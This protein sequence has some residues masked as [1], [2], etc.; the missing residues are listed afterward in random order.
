M[1]ANK[2]KIIKK[3]ILLRENN[4]LFFATLLVNKIEHTQSYFNHVYSSRS[5][6]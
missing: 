6:K 3:F 5:I 4:I 2:P 1:V